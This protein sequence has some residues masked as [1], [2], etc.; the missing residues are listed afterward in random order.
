MKLFTVCI[1]HYGDN[2]LLERCLQSVEDAGED[3]QLLV[4]L[5]GQKDPGFFGN[6]LP[7]TVKACPSANEGFSK[8]ANDLASAAQ[9]DYLVFLNSDAVVGPG[10][11]EALYK[12]FV[13]VPR[14]G[15]TG[16]KGGCRTLTPTGD[17]EAGERITY[18]EGS[19]MMVP[20]ALFLSMG[21]FDTETFRFAY[22]EDS[23]FCLRLRE[24]GWK[25]VEVEV[26]GYQHERAVTSRRVEEEG[27]IDLRG[28]AAINKMR[29]L[30]RWQHV[31]QRGTFRRRI[32]VHRSA[33]RGDV[34]QLSALARI[35]ADRIPHWKLYADTL[36]PELFENNPL[37]SPVSD[38]S[39]PADHVDLDG[40]YEQRPQV[41]IAIAYAQAI[42]VPEPIPLRMPEL[43]LTEDEKERAS[44]SPYVVIHP[45]WT[46]WP[47]KDAPIELW[48]GI[49]T[50]L[51]KRDLGPIA[52]CGDKQT[53]MLGDID[54][55]ATPFRELGANI[56]AAGLF[57]GLDSFPAH[58][59]Y[60]MRTPAVVL[61]GAVPPQRVIVE[62][63]FAVPVQ[64]NHLQCLGCH[65][66]GPQPRLYSGCVRDRLEVHQGLSAACMT[67]LTA[68]QVMEAADKVMGWRK[69]MPT[70]VSKS[71][72]LWRE[73]INGFGKGLNLAC[74][75]SRSFD[76]DTFDR[77]PYFWVDKT[78]DVRERLPYDD[79][80]Y[81]W[82]LTSHN[83]EDLVN[84]DWTVREIRRILRKDGRILAYVP[85]KKY[86]EQGGYNEDHVRIFDE[87]SL[88]YL[89]ERNG[90]SNVNIIDDQAGE[91]YSILGVGVKP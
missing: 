1:V 18:I 77:T 43:Y 15:V 10:W 5:N 74:G 66:E 30:A 67:E 28:I 29:L 81:D 13:T 65:L 36:W 24:R 34:F 14:V 69:T 3:C 87:P 60:A 91:K 2:G 22:S 17:G 56:G 12:P 63:A 47:G 61:F 6:K 46:G 72:E 89:L 27:Q 73:V 83:L 25:V 31:I 55:R 76:C 9:T 49:I 88:K 8:P 54:L 35:V 84:P 38:L 19:C 4:W 82:V 45:G 53:P 11:L 44:P 78:G 50:E 85:T 51:R 26:P 48:E 39:G 90:F 75:L 70:E 58:L 32:V 71:P 37:I 20:R 33:A 42:G 79:N 23:D 80:S 64:A 40:A 21:G 59:A 52:V 62:R 57:I 86:D 68:A 16:P 41:P 7:I